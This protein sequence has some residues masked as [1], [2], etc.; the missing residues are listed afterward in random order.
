MDDL[1]QRLDDAITRR[2]TSVSNR[3]RVQGRLDAARKAVETVEQEIRERGVEP[4]KLDSTIEAVQNKAAGL[5][6]DL[7]ARIATTEK[8]LEPFVGDEI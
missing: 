2:D 5:V 8:A 4:E 6:A 1:K 7:E 3:D